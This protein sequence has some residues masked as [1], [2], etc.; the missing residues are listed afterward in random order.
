MDDYHSC[1][2]RVVVDLADF[3]LAPFECFYYRVDE[4]AGGLAVGNFGY[5]QRLV[6]DLFD[7]G[8]YFQ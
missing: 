6:V 5:G 7:L 3:Y 4:C 8:A 2:A 1:L